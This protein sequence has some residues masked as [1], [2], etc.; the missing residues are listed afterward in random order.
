MMT[1]NYPELRDITFSMR[2]NVLAFTQPS[3]VQQVV[4]EMQDISN[5]QICEGH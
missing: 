1:I 4:Y 5:L 2:E 3:R